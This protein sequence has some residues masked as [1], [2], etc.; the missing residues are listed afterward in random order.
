MSSRKAKEQQAATS[1][2]SLQKIK[3]LLNA[4]ELGTRLTLEEKLDNVTKDIHLKL[5]AVETTAQEARR[6]ARENRE[7]IEGLKFR[8]TELNETFSKQAITIHQLDIEVEDLKNRSLRKTLVFR[9]IK[10]QQS[11]NTWDDIK[12]V[13]AN[14]ISKNMQDFSKEEIIKNIER[15]HRVTTANRNPSATSAPPFLVA[16]ITNWDM[17]E[18]IKSA[19]IKANQEGKSAVFVSQ[20][21]SKSLTERRNAALKYRADLKEQGTSVEGYVKFPATI[22]IKRNGERKYSLKKEF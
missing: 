14:E 21:Y 2:N 17:A 16:K 13:P 19:I 9:N 7:D 12:M 20:M 3:D 8:L 6:Y 22:M 4:S 10:K 5:N 18:K 15:A 11:E 1:S